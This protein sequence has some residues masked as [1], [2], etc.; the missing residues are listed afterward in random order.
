MRT[1]YLFDVDGTLTQPLLKINE[2]F[3][4]V[5]I[6]W[7]KIH[8]KEVYLVTGSDIKKTRHQLFA[9]FRNVCKGIF[10]CAGNELWDKNKLIYRNEFK[11]SSQLKEDLDLY[12]ENSDYK[13]KTGK[14]LEERGGM[15]NFSTVGRNANLLQ[16]EGYTKWDKI[17]REREDLARYIIQNHPELD[18]AIGGTI[19]VDIY[20][21]GKDKSQVVDYLEGSYMNPLDEEISFVFVGDKNIP[22]GNDYALA[23]RLEEKENAYWFQVWSPAETEALIRHS[24][25]FIGEGGV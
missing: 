7:V 24:R 25:L 9:E 11:A 16:R 21:K 12:L 13:F 15:I 17:T 23:M 2:D 5:F 4:G 22:G 3:A 10:C 20:P 6:D 18:V 8:K 1:I 19:S 14:H